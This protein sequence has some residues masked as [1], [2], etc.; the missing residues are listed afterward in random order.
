MAEDTRKNALAML[1]VATD[2]LRLAI[3][4]S[5]TFHPA[6]AAELAAELDA[7]LNRVRYQLGRL[8]KAGV[9]D[10][11][12]ARP[13]R[14]VV[15]R[16]YFVR[17]SFISVD[18]IKDVPPKQLEK[19]IVEVL[20]AVLRDALESLRAGAFYLR[21]EFVT[22]RVPLR[23]DRRGWSEAADLHQE[24]LQ[25]LLRLQEQSASRLE[26]GEEEAG[27]VEEAISAFSFLLLFEAAPRE[28]K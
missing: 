17:R 1:E 10:L 13:R 7:P 11:R 16:V 3:V 5:L 22:M 14:G 21:D 19:A 12:E 25:R 23:V 6:T 26:A 4:T 9:A 27:E 2:P 24:M 20:R 18:E 15:E 28:R 8:R